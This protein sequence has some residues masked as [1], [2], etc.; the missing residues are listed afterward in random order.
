MA[1]LLYNFQKTPLVSTYL[2]YLGVGEFEYLSGK[3]GK[4]QIRVVTTKGNTSKGKFSL[5]L[6][7]KLDVKMPGALSAESL[8]KTSIKNGDKDLYFPVMKKY[9]N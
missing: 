3:A 7:K 5:E 8:L 9:F 6:G 4:I 2:I 1:V